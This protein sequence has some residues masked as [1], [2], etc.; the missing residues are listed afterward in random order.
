MRQ[1]LSARWQAE[2]WKSTDITDG[3]RVL[4]LAL[5]PRMDA[6]GYVSVPRAELTN[7]LGRNERRIAE[8]IDQALAA[9]FLDRVRRGQKGVTAV[10]RVTV[11]DV[12]PA[13]NPH[14]DVSVR[15]HAE[16][17]FSMPPGGHASSS[18]TAPQRFR[19]ASAVEP[20]T[21]R[22]IHE[23]DVDPIAP[24]RPRP[25]LRVVEERFCKHDDP[26]PE[27]C[28]LCVGERVRAEQAR[29]AG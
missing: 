12:Q 20:S 6:K 17:L 14:A 7:L 25:R 15:Q 28:Q 13:A 10:Y 2:V 4:L 23:V 3:C 18:P 9:G 11:P 24:Q 16:K 5:V 29:R 21:S 1:S 22:S 26:H 27:Q 19:R 8:R